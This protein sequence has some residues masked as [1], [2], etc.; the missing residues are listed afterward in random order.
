MD[1]VRSVVARILQK[2]WMN[3]QSTRFTAMKLFCKVLEWYYA[4]VKNRR[5]TNPN[6]NSRLMVLTALTVCPRRL[7]TVTNTPL[8]CKVLAVMEDV[9]V[10]ETVGMWEFCLILL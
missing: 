6:R 4:F 7:P 8:R 1:I 9:Y 10:A 5:R 3:G 2:R